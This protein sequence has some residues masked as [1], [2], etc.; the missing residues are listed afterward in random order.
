MARR[1]YRNDE[2]YIYVSSPARR[3]V[4]SA[5]AWL[6]VGGR[7]H[8]GSARDRVNSVR[9]DVGGGNVR[10]WASGVMA[11]PRSITYNP[12]RS[13]QLYVGGGGGVA[14]TTYNGYWAYGG[15]GGS[16]CVVLPNDVCNSI[17]L[18]KFQREESK[19]EAI[20]KQGKSIVK[21]VFCHIHF[22]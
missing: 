10:R 18:F 19:H 14:V 2:R 16:L 4:E 15:G 1:R 20:T 11:T 5:V 12:A 7:A 17:P 3:A 13:L 8:S 22:H 21:Q 6:C 9:A